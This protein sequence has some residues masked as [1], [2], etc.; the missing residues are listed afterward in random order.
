LTVLAASDVS[1]PRAGT[2]PAPRA[3]VPFHAESSLWPYPRAPLDD[4]DDIVELDFADTSALSDVDAFERRRQNGKNGAKMSKKD[5][6][7]EREEIERSWDVP[8][9]TVTFTNNT[10]VDPGL[11]HPGLGRPSAVSPSPQPPQSGTVN[12][13]AKRPNSASAPM[14]NPAPSSIGGQTPTVPP[15]GNNNKT[16]A[17][18]LKSIPN[19]PNNAQVS[20]PPDTTTQASGTAA[21]AKSAASTAIV[22]A[23]RNHNHPNANSNGNGSGC[24]SVPTM[25]TTTTSDRN[26]FVREVL[27][28][29]RVRHLF[30]SFHSHLWRLLFTFDSIDRFLVRGPTLV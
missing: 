17:A 22:E 13:N 26:E 18:K 6:A 21:L 2:S 8:G 15:Y 30:F 3:L 27:S 29:I 11:L 25:T 14:N 10:N 7:R 24:A 9:K 16:K 5:R 23:V 28:L 12:A 4:R 1:A 19:G 20:A